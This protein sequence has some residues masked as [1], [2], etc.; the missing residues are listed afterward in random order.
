[1]T[2][3]IGSKAGEALP[4]RSPRRDSSSR[5][6]NS[7]IRTPTDGFAFRRT[8]RTAAPVRPIRIERHSRDSAASTPQPPRACCFA[9]AGSKWHLGQKVTVSCYE[10]DKRSKWSPVLSYLV[11][12]ASRSQLRISGPCC[13]AR[14][15]DPHIERRDRLTIVFNKFVMEALRVISFS[16]ARTLVTS[17]AHLRFC[18][19]GRGSQ[20]YPTAK[21][22]V[23]TFPQ[24]C[25]VQRPAR[26]PTAGS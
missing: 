10:L 7:E 5:S 8:L 23:P 20:G 15:A 17:Y 24:R 11:P 14:L 16:M 26:R 9:G 13:G 19:P 22:L 2:L 6:M 12:F 3:S 18:L 25:L 1:M 4:F 21:I